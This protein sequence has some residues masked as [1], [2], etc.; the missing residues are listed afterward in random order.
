MGR[1]EFRGSAT[2]AHGYLVVI[3]EYDSEK[4]AWEDYSK[5]R[6]TRLRTERYSPKNLNVF[7]ISTGSYVLVYS[8]SSSLEEAN[9]VYQLL[10]INDPGLPVK[11]LKY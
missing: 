1:R 6:D 4:S 11:L 3:G 5:F 8:L 9:K 10:K 2:Q 7:Q